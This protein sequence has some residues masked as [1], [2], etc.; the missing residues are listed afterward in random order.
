MPWSVKA[1]ELIRVQY[2][3]VAAAGLPALAAAQKSLE[4]AVIRDIDG[5]ELLMAEHSAVIGKIDAMRKF[6]GAYQRYC[7]KVGSLADLRLAPFHILAAEGHVF[8]DKPHSWHMDLISRLCSGSRVPGLLFATATRTVDLESSQSEQGATDWWEEMTA[9]GGEGMVVK[10]MD[11]TVKGDRGLLQPAIK[12]RGKEYLRIIYGPH[13]D[14]PVNL[15]RLKVRSTASKRRLAIIEYAL[16]I[17]ALERFVAKEPLRRVHE[18]VFGILAM[19]SEP[20]DPRL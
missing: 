16:G 4:E 7:W 13:Y 17:E 11:F 14:S 1:Q 6:R 10:P 9:G 3:S 20:V 18:C 2:A 19:E 12:V 8:I 15:E 5:K